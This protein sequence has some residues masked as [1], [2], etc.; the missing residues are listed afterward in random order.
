MNN[1]EEFL[2]AKSNDPFL[3]NMFPKGTDLSEAM[4]AIEK[5]FLPSDFYMLTSCIHA[6]QFRTEEVSWILMNHESYKFKQMP[7]YRKTYLKIYCFFTNTPIY[8]YY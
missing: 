6:D 1:V 8:K 7:W 4:S 5:H 2:K 3:E